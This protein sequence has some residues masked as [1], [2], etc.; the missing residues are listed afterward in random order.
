MASTS[1][2]ASEVLSALQAFFPMNWGMVGGV[3]AISG[4]FVSANIFRFRRARDRADRR[5]EMK[6]E[7]SRR[8]HF[9]GRED[10]ELNAVPPS[11]DQGH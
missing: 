9:R 1:K 11:R 5:L 4:G 2:P 7:E 6:D 3:V 10:V 8:G